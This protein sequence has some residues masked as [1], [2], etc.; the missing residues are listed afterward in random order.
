MSGSSNEARVAFCIHRLEEMTGVRE[1][2]RRQLDS[3]C[4]GSHD[5]FAVRLALEEAAANAITH[6][7]S[8]DPAKGVSIDLSVGNAKVEMIL[9]DEGSGFDYAHVEDPTTPENLMKPTG[10]GVKLMWGFMDE[11]HFNDAGNRVRLVK[12]RAQPES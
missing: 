4:F 3:H 7:N 12:Y 6:G 1:W 9:A 5:A 8:G 2:L 11:V 10:R